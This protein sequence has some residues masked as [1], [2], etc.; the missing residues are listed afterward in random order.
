MMKNMNDVST[1]R[2]ARL[3]ADLPLTK[4]L[5][6]CRGIPVCR[7]TVLRSIKAGEIPHIL[8]SRGGHVRVKPK[9]IIRHFEGLKFN[10]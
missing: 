10:K 8:T 5:M 1:K 7:R 4:A 6:F 3:D 2:D 9:D